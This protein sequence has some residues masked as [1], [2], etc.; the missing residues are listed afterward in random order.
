[1][2]ILLVNY[3]KGLDGIDEL[4]SEHREYL[5]RH[6]GDG[7]F[8]L[9]GRRVPR[10]GGAILAVGDDLDAITKVTETDPFVR[11][12]LARYDIIQVTV[13]AAA[14]ALGAV[15]ARDGRH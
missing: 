2:F 3:V 4:M 10:T 8:V 7:T 13:T 1:M 11:A 9:S 12:G 15:F 14:E 6:Y 5:D